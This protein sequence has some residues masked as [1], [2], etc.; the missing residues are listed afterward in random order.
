[1]EEWKQIPW[2]QVAERVQ[3]MTEKVD[4]FSSRCKKMPAKLRE[5]EAY[6]DLKVMI[7][8]FTEICR[9]SQELSKESIKQRHWDAVMDRTGTKFDVMAADFKLQDAHG[10][11]HRGA[12]GRDRGDHGR[13]RQAA[14]DRDPV[15]RDRGGWETEEFQFADWKGRNV[16]ILK[17]VVPIVEEL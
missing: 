4:S 2:L 6:T 3:T 9:C 15:G 16:P 12:Q 14:Q 8:D 11:T 17:A 1:M 5:W 13:R 7:D 10:R